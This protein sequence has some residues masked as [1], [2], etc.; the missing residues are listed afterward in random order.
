MDL[1][2]R[3]CPDRIPGGKDKTMKD[4]RI[5][6]TEETTLNKLLEMIGQAEKAAKTPTA[7]S[8]RENAGA[9]IAETETGD[10]KVYRNGYAVYANGTGT[11]VLWLADC[12]S[13]TYRFAQLGDR[14]KEY[15]ADTDTLD[16]SFLGVQPWF[17]AVMVR[18]GHQVEKN[19]MN[20]QFDRKGA[21]KDLW[22]E[23]E[24]EEKREQSW[25]SGCHCESPEFVYIRKETMR[26]QLRKLTDKQ[27]EVFILYH[28]YGYKQHE[29]AEMLGITQKAVDFRLNSAERKVR[30]SAI[31]FSK[32]F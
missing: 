13:F 16:E 28:G 30:I 12:S 15:M 7:K 9:P 8:L 17:M 2:E 6:V 29:I 5:I 14:E 25:N 31:C 19:S 20:R 3:L 23:D 27:R 1:H 32:L 22:D 26:E 4:E 11:A 18:G 21:K 24:T 10:C